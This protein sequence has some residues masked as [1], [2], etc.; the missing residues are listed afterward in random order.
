MTWNSDVDLSEG[1]FI[2][3]QSKFTRKWTSF[4][5]ASDEKTW[6][7]CRLTSTE[8]TIGQLSTFAVFVL[9]TERFMRA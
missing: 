2:N 4:G 7:V 1:C 9:K 8:Q 6:E 3:G 5:W